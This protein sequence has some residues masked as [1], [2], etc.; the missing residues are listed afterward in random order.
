MILPIRISMTAALVALAAG[1]AGTPSRTGSSVPGKVNETGVD[2]LYARLE[3][4][5]RRYETGLAAARDGEVERARTDTLAALDDH[6]LAPAAMLTETI[7]LDEVP[8]RFDR[9][10]HHPDGGKVAIVP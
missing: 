1:C 6:S 8:E 7:T 9:L 4:D 3:A 10:V 2:A 5:A